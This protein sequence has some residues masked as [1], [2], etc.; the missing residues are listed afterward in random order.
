MDADTAKAHCWAGV[1]GSSGTATRLRRRRPVVPW[2]VVR[3]VGR[4]SREVATTVHVL[5]Q[6]SFALL[7]AVRDGPKR[8][9][10][11]L[12][13]VVAGSPAL[14]VHAHGDS[15]RSQIALRIRPAPGKS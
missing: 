7:L 4:P 8:Q 1:V 2:A 6:Q 12:A 14:G 3:L 5:L 11:G 10:L 9:D 13:H 15:D